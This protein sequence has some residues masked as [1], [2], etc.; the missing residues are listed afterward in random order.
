MWSQDSSI[1][2]SL[3]FDSLED[4]FPENHGIRDADDEVRAGAKL[5][6]NTV[7]LY[8]CEMS[9]QYRNR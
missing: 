1:S 8:Q 9:Y 3:D 6:P 5:L 7:G 2:L 4:Q